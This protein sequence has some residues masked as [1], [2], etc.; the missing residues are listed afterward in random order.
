MENQSNLKKRNDSELNNEL[1]A[2]DQNDD[3]GFGT[4]KETSWK[5]RQRVLLLSSRGIKARGRHLIANLSSL[6][7]HHKRETKVEKNSGIREQIKSSCELKDCQNVIFFEQR[8]ERTYL[9]LA[10]YENG[11]TMK[12]LIDSIT[13]ADELKMTG[14]CLKYS[15]PILSFDESFD[16][17]PKWVIFKQLV[18]DSFGIPKFHPKSQPF[19][20]KVFHFGLSDGKI[21]FRNYQIV[22][23]SS[24]VEKKIVNKE[25]KLNEVGPR[26]ILTPCFIQQGLFQGKLLY[27]N[28]LFKTISEERG[29]LRKEQRKLLNQKILKKEKKLQKRKNTFQKNNELADPEQIYD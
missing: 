15:R 11:P 20:D 9:Y 19:V 5:N 23:H 4:G 17:D 3:Y 2:F 6:L 22:Y 14:N 21:H 18:R 27:T 24:G 25:L 10:K 1:L 29:D 8:R 12:F 28:P 7:A 26:L 16:Q 13:T